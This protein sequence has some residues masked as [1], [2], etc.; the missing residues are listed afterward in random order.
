MG[1][2]EPLAQ[3]SGIYFIVKCFPWLRI[4]LEGSSAEPHSKQHRWDEIASFWEK[5]S[6][7]GNRSPPWAHCRPATLC[8][9]QSCGHKQ[10]HCT[11]TAQP[12]AAS[13]AMAQ[14]TP[15]LHPFILGAKPGH[16]SPSLENSP[17]DAGRDERICVWVGSNVPR[18]HLEHPVC[19]R[20]KGLN[21][22]HFTDGKNCQD[23]R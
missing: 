13:T 6:G 12:R 23:S 14:R 19:G 5:G 8:S 4:A 1:D 20:P 2:P 22:C 16:S 21:D 18:T 11:T 9:L 17:A 7:P 3:A 10:G 15:F